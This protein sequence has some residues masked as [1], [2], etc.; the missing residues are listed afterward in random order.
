VVV[1]VVVVVVV[2]EGG[3][4]RADRTCA[5]RRDRDAIC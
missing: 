1:V 2:A 3:I 5:L 4:S